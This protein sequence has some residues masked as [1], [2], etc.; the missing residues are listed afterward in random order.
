MT[1]SRPSTPTHR[2]SRPVTA[3]F[4]RFLYLVSALPLAGLWLALLI[5]GWTVSLVLAITPLSLGAVLVFAGCVRFA[6]WIEG[7]LARRLLRAQ[8]S[9]RRRSL[10]GGSWWRRGRRALGD[11]RFWRGQA[12]LFLRAVLGT[13]TAGVMLSFVAVGLEGVTAPLT[14]RFLPQD[15]GRNGIDLGFWRADTTAKALLLVPAGVVLLAIAVG[16][17]HLFGS[18]WRRIATHV[19]GDNDE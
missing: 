10:A 16:L 9:P 13:I 7:Y 14:Y 18:M 11:G 5:T 17:V 2:T 6:V 4:H 1:T 15:E 8:T 3:T 12:F 19:I